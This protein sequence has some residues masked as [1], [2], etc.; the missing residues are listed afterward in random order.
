MYN[1][2]HGAL[3]V[4]HGSEAVSVVIVHEGLENEHKFTVLLL[5]QLATLQQ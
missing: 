2:L 3:L 5:R 4:R 1:L